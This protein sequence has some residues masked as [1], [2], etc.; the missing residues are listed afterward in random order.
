M[1]FETLMCICNTWFNRPWGWDLRF[2]TSNK[3]D[4][5]NSAGPQTTLWAKPLNDIA[6]WAFTLWIAHVR[7]IKYFLILFYY[8]YCILIAGFNGCSNP[9]LTGPFLSWNSRDI[10]LEWLSSCLFSSS[11]SG[12]FLAPPPPIP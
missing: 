6:P 4:E 12:F 10:T 9:N 1:L 8:I 3:S 7:F 11:L 2:C 5:A